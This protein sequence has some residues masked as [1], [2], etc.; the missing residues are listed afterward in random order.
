MLSRSLDD[1]RRVQVIDSWGKTHV[2][3][4]KLADCRVIARRADGTMF[5]SLQFDNG[6]NFTFCIPLGTSI[7]LY[8]FSLSESFRELPVQ[9]S[10]IYGPAVR[11]YRLE[12]KKADGQSAAAAQ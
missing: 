8:A 4:R 6:T 12:N 10:P 2:F 7:F 1:L 9:F 5:A 3:M 11:S